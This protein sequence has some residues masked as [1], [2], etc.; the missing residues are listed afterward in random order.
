MK[1]RCVLIVDDDE[2]LRSLQGDRMRAEGFLVREAATGAKALEELAAADVNVVVLDLRLPDIDGLEVLRRMPAGHPPVILLTA[3]GTIAR[4]V[5]AMRLGAE[6]FVVKPSTPEHIRLV[7]DRALERRRLSVEN[8]YL[9]EEL[10]RRHQLV[11]GGDSGLAAVLEM[12]RRAA[13]SDATVLVQGESGTGK[14]VLARY[15]HEHS[16]RAERPFVHIDCVGLSEQLFESDL[17]GH[18]KGAFTDAARSKDGRVELADGGTVF[19]DEIGDM[20]PS[21]Q[22]KLLRFS[23]SGEFERVGDPRPRHVDV[24]L[25]AASN[26][27]LERQVLDGS[28]RE[29]LFYRLAV[30][31]LTLPPLRERREDIPALVRHFVRRFCTRAGREPVQV[32]DDAL[33]LLQARSWPGNVRE[34]ANAIERALVMAGPGT[35]RPEHLPEPFFRAELP[36]AVGAPLEQAELEFRRGHLRRTLEITGG[37]QSRAAELLG[38][39]RTYLNR[40]VREL[41]L[42]PED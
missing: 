30:V 12:A 22:A 31:R 36:I 3:H 9:R 20:P 27:D 41:G 34:L 35:L 6:D 42:R 15:V 19:L 32:A 4:A 1:G 37:N 21:I 29:D 38:I 17:F 11:T 13:A 5:E 14:E 8:A 18:E 28:F 24:R 39:S 23:Q 2:A 40:L 26:R 16:P 33:R 7:I 10:G 25:I